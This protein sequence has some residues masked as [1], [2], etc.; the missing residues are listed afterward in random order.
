MRKIK[1]EKKL[2]K[3]AISVIVSYVILITIGIAL[4]ALVYNW[5]RFYVSPDSSE[6][7]PDDI[8]LIIKNYDCTLSNGKSTLSVSIQNKG[9]FNVSGFLLKVSTRENAEIATIILN[10]TGTPLAPGESINF[11]EINKDISGITLGEITLVEVQ[12]FLED[13]SQQNNRLYCDKVAS[14]TITCS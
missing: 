10:D 1:Q 13:S 4:S 14:Q 5:L 9:L 3:K 7:C 12:P 6:K 11:D 8:E 2:G